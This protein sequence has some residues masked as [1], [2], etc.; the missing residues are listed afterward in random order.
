MDKLYLYS[1]IRHRD[2]ML[3]QALGGLNCS[4]LVLI[5]LLQI[6]ELHCGLLWSEQNFVQKAA[7]EFNIWS[8]PR[9]ECYSMEIQLRK[10]VL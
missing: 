2:V 4:V 7:E 6:I 1:I 10:L 3:N 8:L 5:L 9:E